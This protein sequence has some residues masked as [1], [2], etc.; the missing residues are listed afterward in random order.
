MTDE[1]ISLENLNKYY[2]DF[3]VLKDVFLTVKKGEIHGYLGP[4]GAGKTSTIKLILGLLEPSSGEVKVLGENL[5]EDNKKSINVR[6]HIGCMLE[7]D[8][9]DLNSTGLE[10]L[11]YWAELYGLKKKQAQRISNDMIEKLGLSDWKNIVILE[12]F[13]IL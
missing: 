6:S 8:D 3:H 7:H 13:V 1:I 2:G 4:N 12:K 5:Y 9:L 10:N 11:I